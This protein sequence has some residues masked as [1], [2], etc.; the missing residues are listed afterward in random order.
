ME[1]DEVRDR[2]G[3]A[4]SNVLAGEGE[5]VTRWVALVEI[6]D[7][8]GERAVYSM[9]APDQRAWDSLGLLDYGIQL[10]R[11]ALLRDD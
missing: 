5:M 10:E 6:I 7:S 2:I 3:D 11:A 8:H 9:G 1:P 4:F